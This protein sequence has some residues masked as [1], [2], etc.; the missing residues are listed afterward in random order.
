VRLGAAAVV[1]LKGALAHGRT[2]SLGRRRPW[3]RGCGLQRMPRGRCGPGRGR[4]EL[5]NDTDERHRRS[6][7]PCST[8]LQRRTG[9][10]RP[11]YGACVHDTPRPIVAVPGALLGSPTGSTVRLGSSGDPPRDPPELDEVAVGRQR[12]DPYTQPVEKSVD[13]GD[14]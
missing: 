14:P 3:P 10:R 12:V 2:P 11:G 7:P 1:R 5:C 9:Q 4:F 8:S 6:N 13:F